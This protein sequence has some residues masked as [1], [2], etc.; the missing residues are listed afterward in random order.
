M[1][2]KKKC[3]SLSFRMYRFLLIYLKE[4][5]KLKGQAQ[6]ATSDA[7]SLDLGSANNAEELQ[8]QISAQTVPPSYIPV[9]TSNVPV[10]LGS[11]PVPTGSI[12]VPAGNTVVSTN[13][14]LVH[15]SSSTDSFFDDEPTTRFLSLSDLGNH[16]PTPS[17]FFIL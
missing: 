6:R 9:P 11:L 4:L 2:C 12:P 13:D 14:V 5:A 10:P 7:E 1:L 16:V 8:P 17:I 15:T 3:N